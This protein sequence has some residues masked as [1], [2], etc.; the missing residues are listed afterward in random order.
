MFSWDAWY[1]SVVLD[2]KLMCWEPR[3]GAVRLWREF[4][5]WA[6]LEDHLAGLL[7]VKT[8][9]LHL[10]GYLR[11]ARFYREGASS[12]LHGNEW[13]LAFWGLEISLCTSVRGSKVSGVSSAHFSSQSSLSTLLYLLPASCC[14][15]VVLSPA[16]LVCG[17]AENKA[18]SLLLRWSFWRNKE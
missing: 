6:W 8:L 15:A 17:D 9:Y 2:S 11:L 3:V 7:V 5:L 14:T 4:T 10:G 18:R 16:P 1:C 12:P 13:L